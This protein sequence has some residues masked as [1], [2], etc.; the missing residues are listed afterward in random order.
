MGRASKPLRP[1]VHI[2]IAPGFSVQVTAAGQA[3]ELEVS[4][5]TRDPWSSLE[6]FGE[7][8][9]PPYLGRPARPEDSERYQTVFAHR[10]GAVAAPTA[11]LHLSA[12]LL[13][14]LE[15]R[16]V[17][18]AALTLHVGA[19]T[20]LP[21]TAEDLSAHRM[22]AE[23]YEIPEETCARVLA[24]RSDKR[25]VIAVGT[26]VVRALET[27]GARADGPRSGETS[28]LLQPGDPFCVV[29]QLF[30]NFHLPRSTLLALV[31]AFAGVDT[32][33]SAYAAAVRGG[34]RFYSYGDAMLLYRTDP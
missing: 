2:A 15:Q 17:I 10:P 32:V 1:G 21:I 27:W 13:A 11:G 20:F 14:A 8:P 24:A 30:T 16:G 19:G 18:R 12:E 9:V 23:Y 22:H 6:A 28:L 25:P 33:R 29:D 7:L 5:Q 3:G 34:Y 4:L 26:T 31:M